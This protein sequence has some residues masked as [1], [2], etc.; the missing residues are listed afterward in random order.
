MS[1]ILAFPFQIKCPS[2]ISKYAPKKI[3]PTNSAEGPCPP[4]QT[5]LATLEPTLFSSK[6][7]LIFLTFEGTD[8]KYPSFP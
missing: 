6:L 7:P 3:I 1:E 4:T 5:K 2:P 8:L